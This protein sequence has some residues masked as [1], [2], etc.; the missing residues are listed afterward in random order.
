[1]IIPARYASTRFPGKVLHRIAGKPLVQHVYER[2]LKVRGLSHVIVAADDMR[3]AEC[4]F[5]FGADVALTP[6]ALP[7]G[8]DRVASVAASL[9]GVGIVINV[10]GDEPL[11]DPRAIERLCAEMRHHPRL[12]MATL[13]VAFAPDED[14]GDPNKVKVVCDAAGDA[15]YFSRCAI[16]FQRGDVNDAPPLR[17]R[18][19][20]IYAYRRRFLLKLVQTRPT[21]LERAER[22]E[23]LRALHLGARI[24]VLRI[25]HSGPGVDTPG[26]VDAVERLLIGKAQQAGGSVRKSQDDHNRP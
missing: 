22:L 23:Q 11:I 6:S 16:P 1:M 13:A 19:V 24:R 20:G 2:C 12:D 3:V 26:D 7:S 4:A 17:L 25:R 21:A 8:T 10:Q 5:H 15:L 18:H 9:P 14:V